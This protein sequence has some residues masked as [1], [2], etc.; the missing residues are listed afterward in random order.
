L[1]KSREEE[2]IMIIREGR[3]LTPREY[4]NKPGTRGCGLREIVGYLFG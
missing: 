3:K 4:V 2:V 1:E